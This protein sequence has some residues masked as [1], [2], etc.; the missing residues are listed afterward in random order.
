MVLRLIAHIIAGI[1]LHREVTLF[2]G[3]E[4]ARSCPITDVDASWS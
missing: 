1:L 4:A 3:A 2:P